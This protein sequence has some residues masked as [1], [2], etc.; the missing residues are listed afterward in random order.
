MPWMLPNAND[1][2]ESIVVMLDWFSGH[3]TDEVAELVRAKGHVLIFHGGGCTPFTQI[4]DTHLH[5][6]LA[7]Y[8][9]QCENEWALHERERLVIERGEN[10]TPKTKREDIISIVQSVWLSIDHGKVAKKGYQQTGPNMPLRGPVAPE[11]VF[12]DLL[13]VMNQLHPSEDPFEVNMKIRDDAYAFV[14]EGFLAGKWKTWADAHALIEDQDGPGEAL[15]EGLEAYGVAAEDTDSEA[16][17]EDD[18]D[19]NNDGG[20][21]GLS[22]KDALA[23]GGSADGGDTNCDHGN[24]GGD[25][26]A[27]MPGG[28]AGGVV[29]IVDGEDTATVVIV[30]Q[31]QQLS[32]DVDVAQARRVLYED[33][34]R[35][36]DDKMV[37]LMRHAMRQENRKQ[38][39]ASTDIG[40]K[41]K[42]RFE[43]EQAEQ[44]KRRKEIRAE[45]IRAEKDLLQQK[46]V[47]EAARKAAEEA[48]QATLRQMIKDRRDQAAVQKAQTVEKAEKRWLQT[49]FPVICARRCIRQFE[50]LKNDKKYEKVHAQ[51]S[52]DVARSVQE[53]A[54]TRPVYLGILWTEE[55]KYQFYQN[56]AMM[57]PINSRTRR[58]VRCSLPMMEVINKVYPKTNH[59]AASDGC[60]ALRKL[61]QHCIPE[62]DR[63]FVK[64]TLHGYDSLL[65]QNE[66]ILDKAFVYGI[67]CLSRWFGPRNFPWGIYGTWPPKFPE[68]VVPKGGAVPIDISADQG[69]DLLPKF[70]CEKNAAYS[71]STAAASASTVTYSSSPAASSSTATCSSTAAASSATAKPSSSKAASSSKG[72]SS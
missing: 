37:R 42:K 21:G 60:E 22:A 28:G 23:G 56:Y 31:E 57:T 48:R 64:G 65:H 18:D 49:E 6:L 68:N 69:D 4:N 38:K 61:L 35:N 52:K 63:I 71:S 26:G 25:E 2:K 11:D 14:E 5:S 15:A 43:E 19:D 39:D 67:M 36:R 12:G 9:V 10:K 62:A 3:L 46:I 27:D 51:W 24:E 59:V 50:T 30:D 58:Y 20:G 47:E 41:L 44:N 55:A 13:S 34:V 45:E 16:D 33:A 32:E 7:R 66:Y 40:K 17:S 29:H 53:R 8:L 70:I 1:S 54:C 72:K